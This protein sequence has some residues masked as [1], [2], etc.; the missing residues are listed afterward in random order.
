MADRATL[1]TKELSYNKSSNTFVG[2]A[3]EL[4]LNQ[5]SLISYIIYNP[6][7]QMSQYF[8]FDKTDLNND[9]EV[10]GWRYR[11]H[12]GTNLLIIND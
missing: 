6:T 10:M 8:N 12:Q 1:L 4:K 5:V 9:S 3:S 11:S 7:T 2:E